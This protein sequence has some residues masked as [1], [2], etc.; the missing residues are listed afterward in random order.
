MPG[1]WFVCCT[2]SSSINRACSCIF[3]SDPGLCSCSGNGEL[4]C[5]GICWG[6]GSHPLHLG[7]KCRAKPHWDC[8][9]PSQPA[10]QGRKVC[11]HQCAKEYCER[12]ACGKRRAATPSHELGYRSGYRVCPHDPQGPHSKKLSIYFSLFLTIYA[13]LFQGACVRTALKPY[14]V[15]VTRT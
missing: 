11:W 7:R 1:Y 10:C 9:R 6:S 14:A 5:E 12:H 8:D 3:R 15:N 13:M 2:R 4:L